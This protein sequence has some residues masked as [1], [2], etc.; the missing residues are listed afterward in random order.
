MK[1]NAILLTGGVLD[2]LSAKTAHGLIRSTSRFNI[3]GVIDKKFQGEDAGFLLDRVHR[4]IPIYR[5][6]QQFITESK[7]QAT[8]AIVGVAFPG[9]KLPSEMYDEVKSVIT[10]GMSVVSGLHDFLSDR[11]EFRLLAEKHEV[12]LIDIR[13]PR[14]KDQLKFWSGSIMKVKCPVIAILGTDCALGKRT[15][16]C[17]VTEAAKKRGLNA[18][19]IFTGQTGWLQGHNY[20]FILDSTYNDFISGE[21]ENAVVTCYNETSPDVIFIEGQ[22]A[23]CN[24]SGPCGSEFLLSAQ[25]KGVI[26]QHSPARTFFTGQEHTGIK[27]SL[28][29][30]L[31]MIDAFG[32]KVIAITLNT[33]SLDLK[34]ASE[35][36]KRYQLDYNL[37]V[38][39][40]LEEGVDELCDTV[41]R[42]VYQ[43][44][45]T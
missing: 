5:T 14:P 20:G 29:K 4:D 12:K 16:A 35:Y 33:Q 42:Y 32:S 18:Q 37:P 22:S 13:K 10:A 3:V 43:F 40:P 24:P 2:H 25:C 34:Q 44:N 38:F 19:M 30:E 15:T 36:K 9:G 8:H 17:M 23:L 11:E 39:L 26:M 41:Q 21:L 27:I 6:L 1:D 28:E 45:Q 7:A 31:M